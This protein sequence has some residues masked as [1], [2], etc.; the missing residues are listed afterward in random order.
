MLRP[1]AI[2]RDHGWDA[3]NILI[4]QDPTIKLFR[5]EEERDKVEACEGQIDE[6]RECEEDTALAAA[7]AASLASPTRSLCARRQLLW[8]VIVSS[9][10]FVCTCESAGRWCM[11]DWTRWSQWME[12]RHWA[13]RQ[14]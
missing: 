5:A 11:L 6:E 9:F 7:I 14:W 3:L 1:F 12:Q 10:F 13:Q 4:D 8:F 2:G